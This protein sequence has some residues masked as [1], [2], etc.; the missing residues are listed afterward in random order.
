MKKY[1]KVTIFIISFQSFMRKIEE[2][3]GQLKRGVDEMERCFK[4]PCIDEYH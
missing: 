4:V 1:P 2:D 3:L